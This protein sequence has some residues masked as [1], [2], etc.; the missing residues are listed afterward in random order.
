MANIGA[1]AYY[2]LQVLGP[3]GAAPVRFAVIAED[4]LPVWRVTRH[5]ELLMPPGKRFDVLVMAADA[6]T[7]TL[8]SLPYAAQAGKLLPATTQTLATITVKPSSD[9][10]T[11]AGE[12]PSSPG[13]VDDL[14]HAHVTHHHT[15]HFSYVN[16]PFTAQINHH[17]FTPSMTPAAD[18][19][20][21]TVEEWTLINDTTDDHPFHIHVNG[22]QVMS[23]NGV[24]YSAEG[25]QDIVNIPAQ[26]T[27]QGTVH[28][29]KVVIRQRFKT[30]P[31]WFVFHCHILQHEDAGMM[32]T[33]QV[34]QHG[35][36]KRPAPEGEGDDPHGGH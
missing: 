29:G 16:S 3:D 31:G 2:R 1:N 22:F 6:G 34:R 24:A 36:T 21:G 15:F 27:E 28:P 26:T 7:Y 12:L 13:E 9:A 19:Y 30:F 25:H 5:A 33:I 10:V 20:V 17:T 18:P 14:A 8:S 4:G 32:A 11:S 23:V 35:D